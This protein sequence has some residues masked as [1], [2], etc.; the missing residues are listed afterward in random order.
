M[1]LKATLLTAAAIAALA[2][3]TTACGAAGSAP[4]PAPS[5]SAP[6][7]SAPAVA[8]C[9]GGYPAG[10]PRYCGIEPAQIGFSG[11]ESLSI[12]EIT[13]SSWK[14]SGAAG[15]GTWFLRTCLPN[16]AQG[17][18][19]KY[20]AVLT[21]SAARYGT[22]TVLVVTMKGK[23]TAYRYPEPWAQWAKGCTQSPACDHV[24]GLP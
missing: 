1:N 6:A 5:R 18:V 22:F 11:D 20:P 8:F 2:C 9:V 13:W 12:R 3:G 10:A 15:R 16:C 17:P 4:V 7:A 24:A 23:T 14:A 19:I 21:L